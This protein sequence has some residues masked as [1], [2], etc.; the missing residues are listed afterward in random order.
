MRHRKK[1]KYIALSYVIYVLLNF[2]ILFKLLETFSVWKSALLW[3]MSGQ[4]KESLG[5]FD[6]DMDQLHHLSLLGNIPG[7]FHSL[8]PSP[9]N[10]ALL[11]EH[12][13]NVCCLGKVD[14][15]TK[16]VVPLV[17]QNHL[18]RPS[19]FFFAHYSS[20][21]AQ[22][23]CNTSWWLYCG[24]SCQPPINYISGRVWLLPSGTAH[25]LCSGNK[26]FIK[27]CSILWKGSY[28]HL[29]SLLP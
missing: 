11:D 13:F 28:S 7:A 8:Y 16:S 9:H 24:S 1:S 4:V 6:L 10:W 21:D 19:F 3:L 23:S 26:K 25:R 14:G 20:Y 5:L 18:T 15:Q 29:S 17:K 27:H 12:L 2:V 22:L